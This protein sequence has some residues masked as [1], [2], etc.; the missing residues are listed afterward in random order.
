VRNGERFFFVTASVS[1]CGDYLE[2]TLD[3]FIVT[4]LD[5]PAA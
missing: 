4:V 2:L 1:K 5:K 3:F